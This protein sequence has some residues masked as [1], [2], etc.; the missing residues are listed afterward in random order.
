M[1][2]SLFASLIPGSA[3]I[4]AIIDYFQYFNFYKYVESGLKTKFG[5]KKDKVSCVDPKTYFKRFTKYF[6]KL[7]DIKHMLKDAQKTDESNFKGGSTLYDEVEEVDDEDNSHN[8]SELGVNSGSDIEL[9]Q[10]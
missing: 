5:K 3:Y 1:S 2:L 9:E 8:S 6:E 4:L 7:T 10:M